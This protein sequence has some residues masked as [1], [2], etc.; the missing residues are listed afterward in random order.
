MKNKRKNII[1]TVIFILLII[2]ILW[3][4][5]IIPKQIAKISSTMYLKK[6]FSKM[7]LEYVNIEWSASFGDYII[8]FKDDNNELYGFCI[9]PKYFPINLGQGMFEFK[10]IY[11]E[12][13]EKT[14][15]INEI[16]NDI[17]KENI[18]YEKDIDG[19]KKIR[20]AFVESILAQRS[21]IRIEK[22]EDGGKNWLPVNDDYIQIHNGAD[23]VFIDENIGFIND[24][25]LAGTDGENRG[26]MLTNNGGKT[27]EEAKI[28][29]PDNIEEIN[30]FI[31]GVPYEENGMLKLQIYTIK[32]NKDPE[33]TYYEFISKDK[34]KNWEYSKMIKNNQ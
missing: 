1:M 7:Q 33:K 9:G 5:G 28:I 15:E 25:G 8:T 30:L 26:L 11:R 10:E 4:T 22:T 21:I 6:N 13:Y 3:I 24:Y 31:K 19:N 17:S 2:S 23:F 16:S 27:F 20:V 29:H 18:L 12:K 14:K 34:G 32:H